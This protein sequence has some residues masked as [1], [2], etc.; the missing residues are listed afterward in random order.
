MKVEE[1]K[2]VKKASKAAPEKAKVEKDKDVS[3]QKSGKVKDSPKS[4]EKPKVM[5]LLCPQLRRS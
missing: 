3:K 1:K 4:A 2:E 5:Y